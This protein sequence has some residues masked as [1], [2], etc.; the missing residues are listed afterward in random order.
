MAIKKVQPYVNSKNNGLLYLVGTP[1]G[2][3]KDISL[4]AKEI[5]AKADIIFAED[6]RNTANLLHSLNITY[7]KL[8]SCFSY[9]E[10][11]VANTYLEEIKNKNLLACFVSDAGNPGISDPGSLLLTKALSLDINVSTI[12]GP[13]AFLQALIMSGFDTADFT[14]YGFLPTKK[15]AKIAFLEKLINKKETMLFYEA[16]HRLLETLEAFQEVFPKTKRLV[17]ARELTK[18]YEEY[19]YMNIGDIED[20]KSSLIKGEY[21]IVLE[22]NQIEESDDDKYLA[23]ANKLI[24]GGYSISE[25]SKILSTIYPIKKNYLYKLLTDKK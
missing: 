10:E 2:N 3:L 5:L 19:T 24:K 16:P 25:V 22:G 15:Q 21:V 23:Y 8:V 17:L 9:K 20:F 11:S 1:I 18:L 13:S 4:R 14:F 7:K 12:L 6:T